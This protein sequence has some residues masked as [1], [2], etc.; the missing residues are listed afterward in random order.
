M[1]DSYHCEGW[2]SPREPRTCP[3]SGMPLWRHVSTLMA[4]AMRGSWGR[5]NS[6]G[7]TDSLQALQTTYQWGQHDLQS[8]VLWT[9]KASLQYPC[10]YFYFLVV[11]MYSSHSSMNRKNTSFALFAYAL[12]FLYNLV[13]FPGVQYRCESHAQPCGNVPMTHTTRPA[14]LPRFLFKGSKVSKRKNLTHGKQETTLLGHSQTQLLESS[15]EDQG[16]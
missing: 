2:E 4:R 13:H 15:T 3:Q 16:N 5:L 11:D 10:Q 8:S 12:S 7:Y 9:L 6:A 1:P 14:S